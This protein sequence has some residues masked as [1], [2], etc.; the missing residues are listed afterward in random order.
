M[1]RK[2]R[3]TIKDSR[4]FW[5]KSGLGRR[6]FTSAFMSY[7]TFDGLPGAEAERRSR[8][9]E[10]RIWT[11]TIGLTVM[12]V[13]AVSA[14]VY[15][16]GQQRPSVLAEDTYKGWL[17]TLNGGPDWSSTFSSKENDPNWE[18]QNMKHR[19]LSDLT[20]GAIPFSPTISAMQG[21]DFANDVVRTLDRRDMYGSLDLLIYFR[22]VSGDV[23]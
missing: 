11:L 13:C 8:R 9:S 2:T 4:I 17:K 15:I 5:A 1:D 10:S 23:N 16:S 18:S 12:A 14:T 22:P 6:L 19:D 20:P 3:Q 7:Q 21:V